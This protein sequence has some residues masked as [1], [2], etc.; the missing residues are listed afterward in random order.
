[1]SL[2]ESLQVPSRSITPAVLLLRLRDLASY[3][4]RWKYAFA[5]PARAAPL[6]SESEPPE[7]V[8]PNRE[9]TARLEILSIREAYSR[10]FC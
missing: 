10:P 5:I 3:C 6:D 2:Q 4:L 9:M 1:M 8:D 7:P